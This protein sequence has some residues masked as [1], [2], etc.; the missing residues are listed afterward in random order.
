MLQFTVDYVPAEDRLLLRIGIGDTEA[1]FWLTRKLVK[2]LWP[3]LGEAALRLVPGANW[4]PAARRE[5]SEMQ[6]QAE[7]QKLDFAT[8]YNAQRKRVWGDSPVRV[9][10]VEALSHA[11]GN[12]AL[13]FHADNGQYLEVRL[14]AQVH[15][16]ITELLRKAVAQSDWDLQL[17]PGAVAA[18]A[19]AGGWH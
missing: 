15:A 10:V 14:D 19:P 5:A 2:A 3:V 18:P 8:S 13:R 1:L 12:H 7:A 17:D 9:N 6:R 16:G 4:S 11:D